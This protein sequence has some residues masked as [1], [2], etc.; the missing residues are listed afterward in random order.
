MIF[1][2]GICYLSWVIRT[3][4]DILDFLFFKKKN[5]P[6]IQPKPKKSE[7][8]PKAI[9]DSGTQVNPPIL[10]SLRQLSK[11]LSIITPIMTSEI[12]SISKI[13]KSFIPYFVPKGSFMR[14]F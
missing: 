4:D 12:P 9:T 5:D 14:L 7:S 1:I 2:L 10:T 6:I 3:A 11:L 8:V 13:G